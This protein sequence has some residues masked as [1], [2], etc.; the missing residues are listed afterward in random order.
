MVLDADSVAAFEKAVD[1]QVIVSILFKNDF[2]DCR[3]LMI[4][5]V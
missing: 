1:Q 2:F 3:L 5:L 4:V